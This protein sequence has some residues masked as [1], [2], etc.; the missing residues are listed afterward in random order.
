MLSVETPRSFHV[1]LFQVYNVLITTQWEKESFETVARVATGELAERIA[2]AA[3]LSDEGAVGYPNYADNV[4]GENA[5]DE[6]AKAAFGENYA[7]MQ[8]A[9]KE[10]DPAGVFNAWFAVQPAL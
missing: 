10:Y 6:H 1:V 2:K 9:K 4:A 3:S 5:T 8:Q 7:R